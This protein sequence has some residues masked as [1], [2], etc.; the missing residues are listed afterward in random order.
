MEAEKRKRY[1]SV[2]G[3]TPFDYIMHDSL[4]YYSASGNDNISTGLVIG[5]KDPLGGND[6]N[7][8]DLQRALN[9]LGGKPSLTVDGKF[10]TKT[11]DAVKSLNYSYPVY[12]TTF[13]KILSDANKG[14]ASSTTT[15]LSETDLKALWAKDKTKYGKLSSEPNYDKWIKR[16]KNLAGVKDFGKGLF[17]VAMGWLQQKSSGSPT[18][19][20]YEQ[21][22]PEDTSRLWGMPKGLAI[23]GAIVLSGFAL[24]G[25]IALAT[26]KPKVIIRPPAV[27]G[28]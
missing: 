15:T 18:E 19:D 7:V 23:G 12:S 4:Y 27:A 24:W 5:S 10:G 13:Y 3:T 14:D 26:R 1:V 20:D 21:P 9:K 2:N 6:G 17:T 11:K 25:I 28:V 16:H 22:E 8:G